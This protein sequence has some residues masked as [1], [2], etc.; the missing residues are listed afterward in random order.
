MK[1]AIRWIGIGITAA[2]AA[3]MLLADVVLADSSPDVTVRFDLLSPAGGHCQV[4]GQAA[5]KGD[6]LGRPYL[7]GLAAGTAV[8][9]TTADGRSYAIT[10]LRDPRDPLAVEVDMIVA[11]R[12][13]SAVP[14]L[15]VQ[16][17]SQKTP[18]PVRGNASAL[19]QAVR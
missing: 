7:R 1:R 6:L 3:T 15:M 13:G 10:T 11:D 4:G 9:C 2:A 17:N 19:T 16:A 14:M 5:A 8:Q 18:L 12:R